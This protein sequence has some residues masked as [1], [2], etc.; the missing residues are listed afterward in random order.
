MPPLLTFGCIF[1]QGGETELLCGDDFREAN[2]S[3]YHLLMFLHENYKTL[4][5]PADGKI[6]I[7]ELTLVKTDNIKPT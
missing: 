6:R 1:Q 3:D 2:L 7:F 5:F 4:G